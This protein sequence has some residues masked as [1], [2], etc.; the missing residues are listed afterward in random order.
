[1][2]MKIFDQ[3]FKE[4]RRAKEINSV[5]RIQRILRGHIERNGKEKLVLAAVTMKVELKQHVSAKKI[6]KKM[7]GLI[8]R[9]NLDFLGKQCALL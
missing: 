4:A 9:R 5:Y 2:V 3:A 1:M 7:R 6:Q 8:V